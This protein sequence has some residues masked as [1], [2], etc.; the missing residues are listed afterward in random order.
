MRVHARRASRYPSE[1]SALG[2]RRGLS[3]LVR[4]FGAARCSSP[5]T[6]EGDE[7]PGKP[8]CHQGMPRYF[9]DVSLENGPWSEDDGG[10]DLPD[11]EAARVAAFDLALTVAKEPPVVVGAL[12]VRVRNHEPYS[13][14]TVRLLVETE[15]R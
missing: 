1:W 6:Y 10:T 5:F 7:H 11:D 2:I 4:G 12:A 13:L 8:L 14:A 15:N 3:T 9:F